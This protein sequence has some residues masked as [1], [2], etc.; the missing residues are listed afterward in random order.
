MSSYRG[1][2]FRYRSIV[3]EFRL[4]VEIS[5]RLKSIEIKYSIIEYSIIFKSTLIQASHAIGK[6]IDLSCM[7][8]ISI[9]KSQVD[10]NQVYLNQVDWNQVYSN[11]IYFNPS[12]SR[13]R[14]ERIYV[15]SFPHAKMESI[16]VSM[17][18]HVGQRNSVSILIK[19]YDTEVKII[20]I[21]AS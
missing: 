8:S 7:N 11:Q 19:V 13:Y 14:Q 10:W 20:S 4:D 5:S 18:P 3:H 9:S 6:N 16:V 15:A 17:P 12:L 21:D 1:I 2:I